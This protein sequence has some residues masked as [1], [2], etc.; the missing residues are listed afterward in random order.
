MFYPR[1]VVDVNDGVPKW[2]G[3]NDKSELMDVDQPSVDEK[4]KRRRIE[5]KEEKEGKDKEDKKDGKDD[6]E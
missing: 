6:E 3:I 4:R 1:R 2:T 5:E